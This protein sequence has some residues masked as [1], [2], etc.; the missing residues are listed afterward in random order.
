MATVI[1]PFSF[2]EFLRHRDEEPTGEARTWTS[3]QRSRV[4]KRFREFLVEGGFPEAQ[5]L[6]AGLR[7]ELLQ[8]YVDTVLFRDIVERHGVS[9]VA[10]LRWVVRQCLRNPAGRLSAH[11]THQDLKAQGHGVA[12]EYP[13]AMK[14]LLVLDRDALAGLSAPGIEVQPAYEWLLEPGAPSRA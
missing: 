12:K 10:A 14:R 9:Q 8:G 6:A 2:R 11:R 3:A 5:G 1:R 7:I 13:R 4:E